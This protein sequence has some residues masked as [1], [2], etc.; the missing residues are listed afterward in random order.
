[1]NEVIIEMEK[2]QREKA[3]S[4]REIKREKANKERNRLLIE[5]IIAFK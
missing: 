4:E 1:M 5:P 3:R 2:G